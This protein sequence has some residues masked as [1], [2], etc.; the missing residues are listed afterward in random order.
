MHRYDLTDEQWAHVAPLLPPQKPRTGR[1]HHDHRPIINGIQWFLRTGAPWQ[2]L[3]ERY[4][5]DK[6]V[7]SRFYR[8]RAAGIWDRI[9]ATLQQQAD[10]AGQVD[11]DLLYWLPSPSATSSCATGW[12]GRSS[13]IVMQAA[14]DREGND[15][16]CR[17]QRSQ[18][19]RRFRD[20]LLNA[21]VWPR[22]VKVCAVRPE[23]A[24]QLALV[25][26]EQ[27]VEARAPDAAEEPLADG[28]GARGPHGRP[29]HLAAAPRRDAR[30]LRAKRGVVVTDQE[31]RP[32]AEGRCLTQVLCDPGVGRVPRHP[33]MDDPSRAQVDDEEG[34][35]GPEPHVDDG[36]E[37][38]DPHIGGV[39]MQDGRPRLP[40]RA[41]RSR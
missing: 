23:H 5:N 31:A 32:R 19:S 36:S 26:D 20:R 18:M 10:Q 33:D 39:M 4:G 35:E 25:Q 6:T 14:Q 7:S 24:A 21:L 27:V 30:E 41:R 8:W 22:R 3:P 9:L 28:I 12:S 15:W 11:G 1:P 40:A 34:E 16:R 2:D 29:Q 37:V 17:M 13:I 38:A